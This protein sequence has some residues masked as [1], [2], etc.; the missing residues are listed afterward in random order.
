MFMEVDVKFLAMDHGVD[1]DQKKV[2]MYLKEDVTRVWELYVEGTIREF[3]QRGDN[4]FAVLILE[5]ASLDEAKG[6]L[7]TIPFVQ[8]G[9]TAFDVIPIEPFVGLNVLFKTETADTRL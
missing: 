3:Y 5:C 7:S 4:P 1:V 6:K 9:L 2:E 8:H